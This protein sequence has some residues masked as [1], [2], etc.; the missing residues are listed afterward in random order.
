MINGCCLSVADYFLPEKKKKQLNFPHLK[1][2]LGLYAALL[3]S[4]AQDV[5]E[6]PGFH[7]QHKN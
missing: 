1:A 5:Q 2:I 4:L 6:G 3:E 7:H